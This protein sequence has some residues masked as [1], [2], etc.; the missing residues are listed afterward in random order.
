GSGLV[1]LTHPEETQ[2][3]SLVLRPEID[4]ADLRPELHVG[5]RQGLE[6]CVG[7]GSLAVLG[8]DAGID[9]RGGSVYQGSERIESLLRLRATALPQQLEGETGPHRVL[10]ATVA[11]AG[12]ELAPEDAFALERSAAPQRIGDLHPPEGG[13]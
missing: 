11:S 4:G 10:A 6:Q 5:A 8:H 3:E 7:L 12:L 13:E 1:D 2:G 9:P